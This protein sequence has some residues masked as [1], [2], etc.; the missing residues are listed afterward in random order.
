MLKNGTFGDAEFSGDVA[1]AR[2]FI[3][4]FREVSHGDI[5]YPGSLAFGTG[6]EGCLSIAWRRNDSRNTSHVL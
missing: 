4:L 6:T 5:D 2:G 3:T 1:D